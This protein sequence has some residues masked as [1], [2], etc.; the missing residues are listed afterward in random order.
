MTIES[1]SEEIPLAEFAAM[2]ARAKARGHRGFSEE[3]LSDLVARTKRKERRAGEILI[4]IHE[5][6]VF[7]VLRENKRRKSGFADVD[8]EESMQE[9]RIAVL[10]AAETHDPTRGVFTT[11][12][13]LKLR[14]SSRKHNSGDPMIWI[15]PNK[16]GKGKSYPKADPADVAAVRNVVGWDDTIPD[17]DELKI[18]ETISS[19]E[20]DPEALFALLESKANVGDDLRKAISHLSERER[21]LLRMRWS[22][23]DGATLEEVGKALNVTREG[24]RLIEVKAFAKIR[25]YFEINKLDSSSPS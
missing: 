24:A 17:T 1:S 25:R 15:E 13:F 20:P 14:A 19:D 8:L 23:E 4:L 21:T 3:E 9:G 6:F 10:R 22:T 5:P 11:C 12:L 2:R 18:G 16:F 7:K